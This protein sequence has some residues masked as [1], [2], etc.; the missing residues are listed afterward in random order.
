M[1]QRSLMMW[2]VRYLRSLCDFAVDKRYDVLPQNYSNTAISMSCNVQS[3]VC[4]C[5]GVY[6]LHIHH[7]KNC[8]ESSLQ[9]K[10]YARIFSG[11]RSSNILLIDMR[12]LHLRFH[13]RRSL[14]FNRYW[15][16][17]WQL[18]HLIWLLDYLNKPDLIRCLWRVLHA[19]QEI[20][21]LSG[22]LA[23]TLFAIMFVVIIF[24]YLTWFV[25]KPWVFWLC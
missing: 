3:Y 21:T 25:Y 8:I 14:G 23:S 18:I 2:L 24:C 22:V 7:I 20:L 12:K 19:R 10:I 1:Q 11:Y 15:V 9:L 17:V 13:W 16:F 4:I 5:F 6:R